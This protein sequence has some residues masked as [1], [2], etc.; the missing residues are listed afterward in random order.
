MPE[1][2]AG[3]DACVWVLVEHAH[4]QVAG[5]GVCLEAEVVEV[6]VAVLVLLEDFL[7]G[8]AVE[9]R[10]LGEHDVEDDSHREHVALGAVVDVG[11]GGR[12]D[13]LGRDV[14]GRPAAL[15][16]VLRMSQTVERPKSTILRV[17]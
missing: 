2:V 17:H 9:G 1:G 6:D 4:E 13:D 12:V 15:E 5:G 14:A 7:K 10:P 3:G 11:V 16:E 8:L